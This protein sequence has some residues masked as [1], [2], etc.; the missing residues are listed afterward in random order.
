MNISEL[1][2]SRVL[3]LEAISE[4]MASADTSF[5]ESANQQ[6]DPTTATNKNTCRMKTAF[7]QQM[8]R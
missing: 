4:S 7:I 5:A 6:R 3:S 2:F 8:L 1:I